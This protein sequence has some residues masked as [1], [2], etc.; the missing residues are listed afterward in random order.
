MNK[1]WIF[2]IVA[3]I[4]IGALIGVLIAKNSSSDEE[5]IIDELLPPKTQNSGT[6][7]AI[8]Y[9]PESNGLAVKAEII[10]D[11]WERGVLSL[12]ITIKNTSDKK[13]ITSRIS[14]NTIDLNGKRGLEGYGE[15][16]NQLNPG[17]TVTLDLNMVEIG[18]SKSIKKVE[19]FFYKDSIVWGPAPVSTPP[20]TTTPPSTSTTPTTNPSRTEEQVVRD[21]V[22][23]WFDFMKNGKFTE[24]LKLMTLEGFSAA[25]LEAGWDKTITRLEITKVIFE[26]QVSTPHANVYVKVYLSDGSYEKYYFI[27]Y[28]LDNG[29]KI[30]TAVP[31]A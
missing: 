21:V 23:K 19:V 11:H 31:Q 22:T 9:T 8:G 6:M 26:E 2:V 28:K 13:L 16:V 29:W 30:D 3:V 18:V 12:K 17:E 4:L 15:A 10:T 1:K 25:D 7:P 27:L 24:A 5:K 20:K 14:V